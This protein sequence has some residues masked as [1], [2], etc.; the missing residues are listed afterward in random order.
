MNFTLDGLEA[1]RRT[2]ERIDIFRAALADPRP[3]GETAEATARIEAARDAF[4]AALD[5]D[6]NISP[7]LAALHELI[8]DL[9]KR[10]LKAGDARRAGAFLEEVDAVVGLFA[11]PGQLTGK[12]GIS[13][14]ARGTLTEAIQDS[15]VERLIEERLAARAA[16]DFARADAIRDE[17]KTRGIILEDRPDGTR[18]RREA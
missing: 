1:A 12:A 18:W 8:G 11:T 2:L 6:L 14:N 5:D 4:T 16:R 13:L 7:A 3:D 17:L 10:E 15:E 9:N